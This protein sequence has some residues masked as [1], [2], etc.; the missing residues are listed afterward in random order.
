M[1]IWDELPQPCFGFLNHSTP[2]ECERKPPNPYPWHRD[3][4]EQCMWRH[5]PLDVFLKKD[6]VLYH[7]EAFFDSAIKERISSQ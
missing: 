2:P 1:P 3:C 6:N 7:P 5:A 4:V